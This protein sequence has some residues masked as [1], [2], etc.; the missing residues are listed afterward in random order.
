LTPHRCLWSNDDVKETSEE[1]AQL[2][3][4]L[5][6]SARG[7]G[8]HLRDIITDDRRLTAIQVSDELQG[9][10]LLVMATSTADGRPLVGPV[11]GYFLHGAFSFSSGKD[12]VRMRHIAAR[13]F[14]SAT[15]LPNEQLAITV[16]GRAEIFDMADPLRP[17]LRQAML[18]HYLPLQGPAF[19]EWLNEGDS[20]GARIEADKMFTF[21]ME[22]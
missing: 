21:K 16:H 5:D 1:L 19:E 18:D 11:D 8:P 22:P 12:S 14:V 2:Q 10:R 15:Y 4:L 3:E 17:E 13:P 20:W 6:E 9:M 7:A